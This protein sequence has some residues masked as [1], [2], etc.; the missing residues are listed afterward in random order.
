[1]SPAAAS[2]MSSSSS[3][4]MRTRRGTC[5]EARHGRLAARVKRVEQ[6]QAPAWVQRRGATRVCRPAVRRSEGRRCG[7]GAQILWVCSRLP[8]RV[9]AVQYEECCIITARFRCGSGAGGAGGAGAGW[10]RCSA[11]ERSMGQRGARRASRTR[12]K[13]TCL[14]ALAAGLVYNVVALAQHACTRKTREQERCGDDARASA[15]RSGARAADEAARAGAAAAAAPGGWVPR[16]RKQEG[17]G[18]WPSLVGLCSP[19][20]PPE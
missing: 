18:C 20:H 19:Q 1:M 6:E 14:D 3:A 16:S 4:C 17:G 15:Q 7:A 9:A 12:R 5:D 10:R 11:G 8:C 2:W 13:G